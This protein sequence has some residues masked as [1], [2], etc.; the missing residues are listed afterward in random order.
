MK[1]IHLTYML[2]FFVVTIMYAQKINYPVS[3]I[4][5]TLK[6]NADAVIR[7]HTVTKVIINDLRVESHEKFVVTIFNK[8]AQK[9]GYF[10]EGYD[11]HSSVSHYSVKLF[12]S[13]GVLIK[14]AKSKDFLDVKAFDGFTLYDEN[15]RIYY[16]P[17]SEKYP[18]T[19]ELEFSRIDK[20]TLSLGGWYP[21]YDFNVAVQNAVC[22]IITDADCPIRTKEL[23]MAVPGQK[24][25]IDEKTHY[26]WQLVNYNA[27]EEE[28]FLPGYS[29]IFPQVKFATNE[30]NYDGYRGSMSDWKTF[31]SWVREL[32]K[33]RQVLPN[34]TVSKLQ[35][36]VEGID[37]D[38]DKIE[39]LYKYL[40]DN[41]RY[42][43]IQLGIGGWQ[44]FE[45]SL[46]DETKYGDCKAL[47]NYMRALLNAVNIESN[48]IVVRAG[49]DASPIDVE[50]PSQQFNHAI[51][52]VPNKGDTIWLECTDQKQP[53]GYLGSFTQ[54]RHCL[55][56]TE[57]GGKLVKT[58]EYT[59]DSNTQFSTNYCII[60]SAGNCQLKGKTTY[61]ALQYE[62]IARY[63]YRSPKEQ[64]EELYKD[65]NT[66]NS[67]IL[68]Y[69]FERN[70]EPIPVASRQ[71]ELTINKYGTTNGNRLFIPVNPLNAFNF[72]PEKLSSRKYPV[73]LRSNTFDMD[74]LTF[75]LP[76]SYS[77]EYLP[78]PI[79]ISTPYGEYVS[80]G[81]LDGNKFTYIRSL[82]MAKGIFPPEDYEKVREFY[83]TISNADAAKLV[84][85]KK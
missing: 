28:P 61:K 43:S 5:E 51:L 45:A 6:K 62:N 64:K 73:E 66:P 34:A 4:P 3:E 79:G 32:N 9:L 39:L 80:K 59:R 49:K 24:T 19:V 21:V 30:F 8:S 77:V 65:L 13:K 27:L 54:N 46:V 20:Q 83:K 2:M 15:R 23:N 78:E 71:L 76:E 85:I 56:I 40:Q 26:S 29:Q 31:G 53:F 12:D 41:T 42:V 47:S 57:E 33:D 67:T 48:Y 17:Y 69:S 18:Y 58:P 50:F 84:L 1:T 22:N 52:C 37:N 68:N 10:D 7:E 14:K 16:H 55:L 81:S 75:E 72:I 35:A 74:T 25:I 60:D 38:I 11:K 82:K 44:T 63:F 70:N 36:M